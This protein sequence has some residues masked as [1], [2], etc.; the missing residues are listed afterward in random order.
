MAR[1][2]GGRATSDERNELALEP[3][4]QSH[5]APDR[6]AR[7]W[8]VHRKAHLVDTKKTRRRAQ[9]EQMRQSSLAAPMWMCTRVSVHAGAFRTA[10]WP[11]RLPR[12]G[13]SDDRRAGRKRQPQSRRA[14][15]RSAGCSARGAAADRDHAAAT[16]GPS[17]PISISG[18]HGVANSRTS[19]SA[20]LRERSPSRNLPRKRPGRPTLAD[21]AQRR[22]RGPR[23][24][25]SDQ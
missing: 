4:S 6:Q 18:D 16:V 5:R 11:V 20:T 2:M 25:R 10:E 9:L 1:E 19:L 13:V 21:P 7:S 24:G 3:L 22:D 8:S 23:T 14:E 17:A 12:S 15:R